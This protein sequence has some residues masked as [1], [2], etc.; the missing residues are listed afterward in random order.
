MKKFLKLGILILLSTQSHAKDGNQN[1]I[2]ANVVQIGSDFYFKNM[3]LTVKRNFL[4]KNGF[5]PITSSP[6]VTSNGQN[7]HYGCSNQYFI[8]ET[9]VKGLVSIKLTAGFGIRVND[10]FKTYYIPRSD[11]QRELI[12]IV[13]LHLIGIGYD[14]QGAFDIAPAL[15]NYFKEKMPEYIADSYYIHSGEL[16]VSLEKLTCTSSQNSKTCTATL[17]DG[18]YIELD[19]KANNMIFHGIDLEI[20]AHPTSRL[21]IGRKYE[22]LA[23]NGFR[24]TYSNLYC[25]VADVDQ[26]GWGGGSCEYFDLKP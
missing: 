20:A 19:E 22:S 14:P 21:Y 17:A 2:D 24:I 1:K 10:G 15:S 23:D 25:S 13:N 11:N 9:F 12:K 7:C 6:V 26:G 3:E 16:Y 4:R 8:S 18:R 5:T